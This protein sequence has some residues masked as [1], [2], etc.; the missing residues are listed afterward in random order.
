MLVIEGSASSELAR[1]T[2]EKIGCELVKP[3]MR[4][5]PDGELYLRIPSGVEGE[6]VAIVQSTPEPQNDNLM[7]LFFLLDAAKDQGAEKTVAVIPY[8][9]YA[10]QDKRFEPGEAVSVQTLRKI[11]ESIGV[12]EFITVDIHEEETMQTFKIPAK[13]L[14]AMPKI[15]K[16]L[17]SHGL[18]DPILLAPDRGAV[19]LVEMAA[20]S[21]GADYDYLVKKRKTPTRVHM[22]PKNLRVAGRDVVILDDIISTG[23]TI[24]EAT[25]TLKKQDARKIYAGCTH[26][27]LVGGALERIYNSGA[28]EV[29][30]TDTIECEV[31]KISVGSI[32]AQAIS[33]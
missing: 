9:A 16:S 22:K 19:R 32:L 31:S 26:G 7:E 10:R 2:S 15:G 11:I 33:E 5:F 18:R 30:A 27:V 23:A 4:R 14:S 24:A 25:K 21:L 3:E 6:E 13:N 12:D 17:S 20:E 1:R 8:L 29:F 28:D